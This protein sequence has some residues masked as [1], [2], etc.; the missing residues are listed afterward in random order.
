MRSVIHSAFFCCSNLREVIFNEGLQKI[1]DLTFYECTSL[2]SIKLPS[3]LVEIGI[4]AFHS[5][6]NFKKVIF[7]DGLQKIGDGAF[8]DCESLES[9]KLPST[10]TE[11]GDEAFLDCRNLR[12]V[13]LFNDGL[14]ERLQKVGNRAFINCTSL[15]SIKMPSTLVEIGINSFYGCVV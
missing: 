10:V 8:C 9:I 2:E 15:E 13:I 6:S 3:T 14:N 7:K 11:I 5:C 1:G 12:E 4:S